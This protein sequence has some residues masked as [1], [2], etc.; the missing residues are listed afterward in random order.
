M[1]KIE[2]CKRASLLDMFL[3]KKHVML[4]VPKIHNSSKFQNREANVEIYGEKES[5]NAAS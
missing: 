4:M 5:F 3:I 2:T 1:L